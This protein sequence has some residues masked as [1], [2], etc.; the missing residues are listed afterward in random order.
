MLADSLERLFL[1]NMRDVAV[2]VVI[3]V[4]KLGEA[5]VVRRPLDAHVIDPKLFLGLEIVIND[6]PSRPDD[7]HF[8]D[9]SGLEPAA[10]NGGKAFVAERQRH[11]GDVLHIWRHVRVALTINGDGR[12]AEHV[13]ND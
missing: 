8:A 12:F 7:R 10:L 13:E 4:L 6:H 5:I 1:L 3:G 11:V 9:F 2:P